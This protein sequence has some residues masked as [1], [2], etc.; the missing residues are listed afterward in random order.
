MTRT[1]ALCGRGRGPALELPL[2]GRI[3][4]IVQQLER[5][6]LC[7]AQILALLR[8]VKH[9]ISGLIT[10]SKSKQIYTAIGIGAHG[11]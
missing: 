11:F 8:S 10:Y 1:A 9:N 5:P 7:G 4:A 3:G 2:G 6:V